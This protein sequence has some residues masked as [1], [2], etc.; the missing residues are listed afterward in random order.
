[1]GSRVELTP[2]VFPVS[3]PSPIG[4][5]ESFSVGENGIISG[6][7]TNGLIRNIAQ[8]ALAITVGV[9]GKLLTGQVPDVMTVSLFSTGVIFCGLGLLG[10]HINAHLAR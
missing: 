7:F 5:L 6:A 4:T 3:W 10:D 2:D 9:A 1:M 8:V